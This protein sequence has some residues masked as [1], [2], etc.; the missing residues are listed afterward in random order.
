MHREA[1]CDSLKLVPG[2]CL[3][4]PEPRHNQGTGGGFNGRFLDPCVFPCHFRSD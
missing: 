1:L 3:E 2:V 4:I